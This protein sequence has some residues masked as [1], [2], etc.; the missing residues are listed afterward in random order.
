MPMS[1]NSRLR[2]KG[3]CPD[4]QARLPSGLE[5]MTDDALLGW[6]RWACSKS[7]QKSVNSAP[8]GKAPGIEKLTM[9]GL[10]MDGDQLA[11]FRELH[12]PQ[13]L[14]VPGWET[15]QLKL[16]RAALSLLVHTAQGIGGQNDGV[17][18]RKQHVG[19]A[20]PVARAVQRVRDAQRLGLDDIGDGQAQ[21]GPA[22][23]HPRDIDFSGEMTT[24]QRSAPACNG[25]QGELADGSRAA[26]GTVG[27][28]ARTQK[29]REQLLGVS[30]GSKRMPRPAAGKSRRAVCRDRSCT[31]S[32]RDGAQGGR[33]EVEGAKLGRRQGILMAAL[34]GLCLGADGP[35]DR[36]S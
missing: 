20:Q 3:Q 14:R 16:R 36:S 31:P 2:R 23:Q 30:R 15:P 4:A 10:V 24:T 11:T 27:R 1:R 34:R 33:S 18:H 25:S 19:I 29:Q 8:A 17:G 12:R 5:G 21:A 13:P 35:A 22:A 26:A 32:S 6:L 28:G 7:Q 9:A